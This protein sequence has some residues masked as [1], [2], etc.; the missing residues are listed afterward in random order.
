MNYT[1]EG[2][3]EKHGLRAIE[4]G[5]HYYVDGYYSVSQVAER[6]GKRLSTL[7]RKLR[8]NP[9]K[10]IVQCIDLIGQ[11]G[12]PRVSG[13]EIR[14]IKPLFDMTKIPLSDPHYAA[15]NMA[16]SMH[17]N[18]SSQDEIIEA[19]KKRLNERLIKELK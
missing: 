14:G 7:Y 13:K 12:G 19:M 2:M 18:G 16:N 3:A 15:K 4:G 10:T 6:S 11:M 5:K 8:E 1:I 9:E 17:E